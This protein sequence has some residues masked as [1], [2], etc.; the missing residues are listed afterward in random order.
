MA[1]VAMVAITGQDE[2]KLGRGHT[3]LRA[4]SIQCLAVLFIYLFF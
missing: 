1:S 2:M 4:Q 3:P